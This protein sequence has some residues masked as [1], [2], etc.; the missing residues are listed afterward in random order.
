MLLPTEQFPTLSAAYCLRRL[1]K[2]DITEF[3]SFLGVLLKFSFGSF[4]S[5]QLLSCVNIL[6]LPK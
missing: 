1:G 3:I 2:E 6:R 4:S 5:M